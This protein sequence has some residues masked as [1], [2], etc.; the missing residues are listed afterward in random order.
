[1]LKSRTEVAIIIQLKHFLQRI[2]L[3][4]KQGKIRVT[5]ADINS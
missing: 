3:S 2:F 5:L 1:M 4:V